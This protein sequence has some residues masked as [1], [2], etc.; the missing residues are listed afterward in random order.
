MYYRPEHPYCTQ[1]LVLLYISALASSYKGTRD[2]LAN[3]PDAP[4]FIEGCAV[5]PPL[6]FDPEWDTLLKQ[7]QICLDVLQLKYRLPTSSDLRL[8]E[9]WQ[10]DV[11]NLSSVRHYGRN[12]DYWSERFF[13]IFHN[14]NCSEQV[15]GSPSEPG[16]LVS[17]HQFITPGPLDRGT[18]Y[19]F[20]PFADGSRPIFVS[21]LIYKSS[22]TMRASSDII[23]GK[24][25]SLRA[26]ICPHKEG[27]S[28]TRQHN[29]QPSSTQ[30]R[31]DVC[32][33][34]DRPNDSAPFK[35]MWLS[36]SIEICLHPIHRAQ[37]LAWSFYINTPLE[38]STAKQDSPKHASIQLGPDHEIWSYLEDGDIIM[39]RAWPQHEGWPSP[40]V[41]LELT[42][43]F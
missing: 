12:A 37:E 15:F 41:H 8:I 42:T 16:T 33:G 24:V 32:I 26:A 3:G 28:A 7:R 10:L 36:G 22:D 20:P 1:E 19:R 35:G 30:T 17:Y 29:S 13:M 38:K 43:Q 18:V 39:L 9:H 27:A 31:I 21:P 23:T 25:N 34:R 11:Q 6:V 14:H 5:G 4:R 2:I 40:L